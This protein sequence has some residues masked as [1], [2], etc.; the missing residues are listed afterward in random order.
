VACSITLSSAA[1][2][3]VMFDPAVCGDPDDRATPGRPSTRDI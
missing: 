3:V 1:V 2:V